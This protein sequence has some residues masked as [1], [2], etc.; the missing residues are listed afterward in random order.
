MSPHAPTFVLPGG[1]TFTL[2]YTDGHPD[3]LT[4]RLGTPPCAKWK[5]TLDEVGE[6][7]RIDHAAT[8]RFWNPH[9]LAR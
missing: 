5:Y 3:R 8:P 7:V 4:V 6:I 2:P 9:Y 1:Y